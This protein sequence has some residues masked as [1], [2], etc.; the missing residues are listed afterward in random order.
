MNANNAR[1]RS[2]PSA[3]VFGGTPMQGQGQPVVAGNFNTNFGAGGSATGPA[4]ILIGLTLIL[5]VHYVWT[6]PVQGGR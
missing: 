3:S 2:A 1:G 5:V 6:R 4:L